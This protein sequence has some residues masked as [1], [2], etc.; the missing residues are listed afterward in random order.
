MDVINEAVSDRVKFPPS[1]TGDIRKYQGPPDDAERTAEFITVGIN[2][3]A[4]HPKALGTMSKLTKLHH[5]QI[6]YIR[7]N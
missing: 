7:P 1:V 4:V 5:F 6:V 2:V 3:N